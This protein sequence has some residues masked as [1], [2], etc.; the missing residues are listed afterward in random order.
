MKRRALPIVV[1]LLLAP[2]A[3]FAD[4]P[5]HGSDPAAAQSLFYEARAM[6]QQGKYADACPKLE[7]SLRLDAGIGTQ[8]N[9]ADCHEHVGK[10]ASAWA[11][12]LEVAAQAKTA[13]Q[14]ERE[15]VARKRAQTLEPR[16]PK[17]VIDV[18]NTTQGL[19]VKRDGVPVRSAAWGT[20]I[21]VDPGTHQITASA[22]GKLPWDTTVQAAEGKTARVAVPRDL[23]T[24]PAA[25]VAPTTSTPP[26]HPVAGGA[27]PVAPAPTQ[28]AE[29]PAPVVEEPGS[30]QRTIGWVIAGVGVVG[31]GVGAGFG[32]A[33]LNKRDESKNHCVGDLCDPTGVSLR[34]T[35]IRNGNIATVSTVLGGLAAV[36]GLALV[37]TAP[38]RS[39]KQE[40]AGKIRAVPSFA[41][42]GGGVVLS[43]AF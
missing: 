10:V 23:P 34:D 35:A 24:A 36:G 37:L 1:L 19:E 28:T 5:K 3:A 6:M 26:A 22:P 25:V 13:N 21:P 11:G 32:L 17:L 39:E 40:R 4:P 33:S 43:G 30:T 42:S 27:E 20:A 38:S 18:P 16:L 14:A 31:V 7:E 9:L 41:Q 15:K 12:F 2:S 29:F 8:F